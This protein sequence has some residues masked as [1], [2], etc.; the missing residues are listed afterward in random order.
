SFLR[1]LSLL[2][3]NPAQADTS[4]FAFASISGSNGFSGASYTGYT[5]DGINAANN[6]YSPMTEFGAVPPDHI[7]EFRLA[8]NFDAEKRGN[9]GVA[10]ELIT[11]SGTNNFHGSVYEYHENSAVDSRNF[12]AAGVSPTRQNSF[13]F[14]LGGP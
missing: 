14:T 3:Y 2:T 1:T 8:S 6:Q 5:I 10:V 13:G 7:A 9:N 4:A 12:F 11:K